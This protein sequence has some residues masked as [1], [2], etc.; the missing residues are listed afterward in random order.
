MTTHSDFKKLVRARMERTGE[1]YTTAL[2]AL[3]LDRDAAR[4]QHEQLIRSHFEDGRIEH[5]RLLRIPARRRPRFAVVLELLHRFEP[6]AIYSESQVNAILREAHED[7]AYLRR[8]LVDYRL[9]ERDS[10]GTYWVTATAP[11]RDANEAQETGDWERIWLPEFL[12][13]GTHHD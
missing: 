1:N 5:G 6:G 7:V 3:S 4:A 10:L 2:A 12:G 8:E 11:V 9:L 13:A